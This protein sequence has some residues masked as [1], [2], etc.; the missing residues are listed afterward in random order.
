MSADRGVAATAQSMLEAVAGSFCFLQCWTRTLL[1][2]DW[3]GTDIGEVER[4]TEA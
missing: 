1:S 2:A 4:A 3:L